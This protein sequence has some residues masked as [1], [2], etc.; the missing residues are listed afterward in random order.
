[1]KNGPTTKLFAWASISYVGSIL[2][3][4]WLLGFLDP[5]GKPISPNEWG[6]VL[7]GIF[8]PLAFLWLLYASL[9]QRAELELQR[10][11]LQENNKTQAEQH[12]A[13]ERQAEAMLAQVK[14]L[15]AET[16]AKYEPI[17]VLFEFDGKQSKYN[18]SS[19]RR[20]TMT[21]TNV[22]GNI[23][24]I[25]LSSELEPTHVIT[26]DGGV[27]YILTGLISHLFTGE[28]L[29]FLLPLREN[30]DNDFSFSVS[31]KR[32]D[33]AELVHYYRAVENFGRIELVKRQKS[34]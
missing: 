27:R 28:R 17:L 5:E 15:E 21:L 32:L 33:G 12:A 6:D 2:V 30:D 4:A 11:E 29:R 3:G 20:E 34:S 16:D 8:S 9:A 31:M 18:H 19:D 26:A 23:V 22:G 1:M 25:R 13:M 10:K 7:A 24:D 14:R